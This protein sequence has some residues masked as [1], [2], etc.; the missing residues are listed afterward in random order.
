MNVKSK[1][2]YALALA[3][4]FVILLSIS[5][6]T[7]FTYTEYLVK[8]VRIQETGSIKGH[9][10]AIAGL[11]YAAI[12]LRDPDGIEYES[13]TDGAID[14]SHYG[15]FFTNIDVDPEDLVITIEQI[16]DGEPHEGD[17]EVSATYQ[18]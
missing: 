13:G 6:L 9:Y 4:I 3:M 5:G 2:G 7:L 17:Y 11:R 18:Y 16:P 15:D 14:N 1:K 12:L 10:A 8:E